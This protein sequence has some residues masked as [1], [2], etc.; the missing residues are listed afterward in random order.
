[1]LYPSLSLLE[2]KIQD[3]IILGFGDFVP[4]DAMLNADTKDGQYKLIIACLYLLLGKNIR[5]LDFCLQG[6]VIYLQKKYI[7]V[8]FLYA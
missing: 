1:M 6:F 7:S 4:G 5:I 8:S 3:K 2:I